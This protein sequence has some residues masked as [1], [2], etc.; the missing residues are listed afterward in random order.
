MQRHTCLLL[1]LLVLAAG[2]AQ[3]LAERSETVAPD[4]FAAADHD[5]DGKVTWEEFRNRVVAVFGHWDHNHDGRIA[6]D[7][8]P[9]A[10]APGGQ[11]AQPGNVTMESFTA[12]ADAAFRAADKDGDGALS[13]AEWSDDAS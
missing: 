13:R 9:P 10:I 1:A 6:G 2:P 4:A 12:S 7:E 8:H 11:S 5:G 3:S